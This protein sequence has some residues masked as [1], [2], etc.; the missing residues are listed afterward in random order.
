ME[1]ILFLAPIIAGTY[2]VIKE[3]NKSNGNS[4]FGCWVILIIIIIYLV[5]VVVTLFI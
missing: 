4:D 3:I 5:L 2:Y 1:I